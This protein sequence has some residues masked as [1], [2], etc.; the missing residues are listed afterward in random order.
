MKAWQNKPALNTPGRSGKQKLYW[1]R[2]AV[3]AAKRHARRTRRHGSR[4]WM[5]GQP[6]PQQG[7]RK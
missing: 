6:M 5:A 1:G 7:G 2:T 3:V 4:A